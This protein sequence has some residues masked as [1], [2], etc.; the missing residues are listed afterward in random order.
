[1]ATP[2]IRHKVIVAELSNKLSS[3]DFLLRTFPIYHRQ[4]SS[5]QKSALSVIVAELGESPS[6]SASDI[7]NLNNNG[8]SKGSS[9]K[10]ANSPQVAGNHLLLAARNQQHL[11]RLLAYTNDVNGAFEATRK[12][13]MAISS[14]AGNG[15]DDLSSVRTVLDFNFRSVNDLLR[16]VRVSME[17]ISC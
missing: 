4:S 13:Q 8:L 2:V 11:M 15:V 14:A 17:S 16:L 3:S 12:S 5:S 6:S 9:S 7:D 10:D 1:M